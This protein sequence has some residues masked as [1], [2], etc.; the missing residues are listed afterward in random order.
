MSIEHFG[1]KLLGSE[2][3]L[4]LSK[5]NYIQQREDGSLVFSFGVPTEE[6]LRERPLQERIDERY[7]NFDLN[8][9]YFN[10]LDEVRFN[11]WLEEYLALH[12]DF[13]EIHDLK[14]YADV[15]GAYLLV[16]D[17]YKQVYLGITC[18]IRRRIQQHWWRKMP[19]DRLIWGE[20]ADSQLSIDSFR[21]LDTT[22]IFVSVQD[23]G[24]EKPDKDLYSHERNAIDL[25]ARRY[26]LN[27]V[28]T[29]LQ[30]HSLEELVPQKS[31]HKLWLE[32]PEEDVD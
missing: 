2:E 22:R 14:P 8:M 32:N 11:K 12:S 7:T 20:V 5:E 16:L 31:E 23:G 13:R 30:V 17:K 24:S 15:P 19:L 3:E 25:T 6:S 1:V 4:R 9:E 27:R 21:A 29:G 10:G 26:M 18:N 28:M